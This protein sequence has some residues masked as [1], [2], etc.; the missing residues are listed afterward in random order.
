M[1]VQFLSVEV[2]NSQFPNLSI[3]TLS[4]LNATV[5]DGDGAVVLVDGDLY[6]VAERRRVIEGKSHWHDREP[7][8]TPSVCLHK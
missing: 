4:H 5:C 2:L 7:T 8:L 3:D 6:G 1:V